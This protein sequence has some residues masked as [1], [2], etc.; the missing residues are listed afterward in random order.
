MNEAFAKNMAEG[1]ALEQPSLVIHGR[2]DPVVPISHAKAVAG[3]LPSAEGRWLERC[4]HFPQIE[5]AAT[6]NGWLA[7]FLYAPTRPR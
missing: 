6:V 4:G 2:Q 7:D 1:Y 3:G 5:H